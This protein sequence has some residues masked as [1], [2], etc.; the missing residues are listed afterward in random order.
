MS[1]FVKISG[2][3]TD[4]PVFTA[5][6]PIFSPPITP[7]DAFVI[8][9]VAG[10]TIRVWRVF[11]STVQTVAGINTWF[12]NKH[13]TANAGGTPVSTAKIPHASGQ[14]SSTA[15][16]QHYTANPTP[17]T[18]LGSI[19]TFRLNSPTVTTAGLG[20]SDLMIDFVSTIGFPIVLQGP[21]E[22]LVW[23]LAG[24]AL[25]AGLSVVA[26]VMWTEG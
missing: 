21:T 25:P 18:S 6:T 10:K 15:L 9:G 7:T 23:N 8:E 20:N 4:K 19:G 24:A 5:F 2:T 13:S 11:L 26:G 3:T 17:G 1:N 22:G 12:L 14:A 16:V